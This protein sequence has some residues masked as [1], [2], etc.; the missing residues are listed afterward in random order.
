MENGEN[1]QTCAVHVKDKYKIRSI[2]FM[3]QNCYIT[4]GNAIFIGNNAI[5]YKAITVFMTLY[6]LKNQI[7]IGLG[8]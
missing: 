4:K 5:L 7:S 6:D 3:Y 8:Q 1:Q 2:Q